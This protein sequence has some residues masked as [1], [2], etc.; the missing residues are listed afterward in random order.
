[1]KKSK[2]ISRKKLLR[3]L[4]TLA[5]TI[6]KIRDGH[7]CQMCG[8]EVYGKNATWAHLISRT[9]LRLRW[10]LDNSTLLCYHCHIHI[11][12]ANPI[13][14]T[15]WAYKHFGKSYINKLKKRDIPISYSI[16]DLLKIKAALEE[17]LTKIKTLE[18]EGKIQ[19]IENEQREEGN[20]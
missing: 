13:Y 20:K 10:D 7:T 8:N 3:E 18:I 6:V 11:W 12:H 9:S 19:E 1:M 14:A 17:E 16:D 5:A 2:K 15:D 4:D